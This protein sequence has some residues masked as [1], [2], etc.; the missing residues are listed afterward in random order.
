[1]QRNPVTPKGYIALEAELK[2][3]K[4][5]VRIG[6]VRDI[7]E[8]RAHGDI[9]ENAEFE[10]AKERQ[11]MCEGR[12]AL[13]ENQVAAAEVIDPSKMKQQ[14]RIVFGATVDLENEAGDARTYQI[15]GETEFDIDNGKISWKSPLA[16]ALIGKNDGDEVEVPAPGGRQVW[17]VVGVRYI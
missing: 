4:S 8:A 7:E 1:M 5:I 11:S 16:Q 10:D 6:I 15:I 9:S 14:D 13:L 3:Q 12:I 17:E 2:R